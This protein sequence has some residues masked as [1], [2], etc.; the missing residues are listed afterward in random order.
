MEHLADDPVAV[1]EGG[2]DETNESGVR[3]DQISAYALPAGAQQ[4]VG[5][6][7]AALRHAAAQVLAA[8]KRAHVVA[9]GSPNH[10]G[11]KINM[12]A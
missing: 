9:H 12:I 7:D 6:G 1:E 10:I 2:K 3:P 11:T 8:A 5:V 4:Q